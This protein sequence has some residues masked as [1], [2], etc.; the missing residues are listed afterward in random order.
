MFHSGLLLFIQPMYSLYPIQ[1][2]FA[3]FAAGSAF[4]EAASC[5]AFDAVVGFGTGQGKTLKVGLVRGFDIGVTGE[6]IGFHGVLLVLC[7]C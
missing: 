3:A 5:A 1:A 7:S 2:S 6:S 4:E